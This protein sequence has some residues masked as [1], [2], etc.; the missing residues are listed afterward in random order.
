MLFMKIP[1]VYWNLRENSGR[2]PADLP[3]FPKVSLIFLKLTEGNGESQ[4]GW[5]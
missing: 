4:N 2:F 5:H 3:K 1:H